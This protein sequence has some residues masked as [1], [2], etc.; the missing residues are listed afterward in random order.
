M[1]TR[2][3]DIPEELLDLLKGSRLGSR[4]GADQVR[5]VLA[6]HLFLEGLVSIG[7]AAELAGEPRVE[8]EWLLT[9]MGLPTTRYELSDY[10][11]DLRGLAEAERRQKA[12]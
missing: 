8:F 6:I 1:K 2:T 11:E 7:K 5:T 9:E 10:E 4:S 12:S 3:I